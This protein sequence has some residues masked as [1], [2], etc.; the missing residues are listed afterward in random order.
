MKIDNTTIAEIS[1]FINELTSF[2]NIEFSP[3][4]P[5]YP[6]KLRVLWE[7]THKC[8]LNCIHCFVKKYYSHKL[9]KKDIIQL[10][11]NLK[12]ADVGEL[13]ISGGEP[14]L[15]KDLPF[16]IEYATSLGLVVSLSSNLSLLLSEEKIKRIYE[17]GVKFVH[18]S[19][20][21]PEEVHNR[22]RGANIFYIFD[23]NIDL[24]NRIG[25]TIG[26][27]TILSKYNINMDFKKYFNYIKTK[28]IK[29]VS[30]YKAEPLGAVC[31]QNF[32]I[33]L[34]EELYI[35]K[36]LLN[37]LSELDLSGIEIEIIRFSYNGS[38]QSCKAEKFFSLLPNC[39]LSLCPW[40]SKNLPIKVGNILYDDPVELFKRARI[41]T[42][43]FL[44]IFKDNRNR[45]CNNCQFK[46]SCGG[47]CVA[48]AFHTNLK[49][50]PV[51]FKRN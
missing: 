27:S 39:E 36:K 28:E 4:C 41:Y 40:L 1:R 31:E 5:F 8:N 34:K 14:F 2:P 46:N 30:I 17:A 6:Q 20:D 38:L 49:L 9:T 19:L 21:G 25:I 43:K 47:G 15:V 22:I 11:E 45:N 48:L 13:W 33:T 29:R 12:K 50:D 26:I 23:K 32:G 3:S 10:L 35:L 44:N 24:I 7:I 51:C 37:I 42:K 16:V 18:T